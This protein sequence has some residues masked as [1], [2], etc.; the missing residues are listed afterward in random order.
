MLAIRWR[1]CFSDAKP[2]SEFWQKFYHWIRQHRHTVRKYTT[3]WKVGH[4][5]ASP[6]SWENK[7]NKCWDDRIEMWSLGTIFI[8]FWMWELLFYPPV[9]RRRKR[10]S[11]RYPSNCCRKVKLNIFVVLNLWITIF[12]AVSWRKTIALNFIPKDPNNITERHQAITWTSNEPVQWNTAVLLQLFLSKST[13][14]N[15]SYHRGCDKHSSPIVAND[16][17]GSLTFYGNNFVL[18]SF[19]VSR[20]T[21]F[22][23]CGMNPVMT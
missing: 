13:L 18:Q 15:C 19:D 10:S 4:S 7:V 22:V 9:S 6:E 14:C 2:S 16:V 17:Y 1:L 8:G 20:L 11:P 5:K 23:I 3:S 12:N 21:T